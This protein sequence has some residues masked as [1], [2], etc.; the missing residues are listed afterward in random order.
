MEPVYPATEGVA[1]PTVRQAS[2]G[3]ALDEAPELPEWQDPAW[4]KPEGFASRREAI[5]RLPDRAATPTSRLWR[6]T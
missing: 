2:P 5:A 4:L 3:E 6:P 1:A